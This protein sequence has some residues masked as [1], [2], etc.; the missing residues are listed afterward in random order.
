MTAFRLDY[1]LTA[2]NGEVAVGYSRANSSEERP[3]INGIRNQR[4]TMKRQVLQN[5]N[6]KY[7]GL[8]CKYFD[9]TFLNNIEM[10]S[11]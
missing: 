10:R 3:S 4:M 11:V 9:M 8:Y 5:R 2:K 7:A 6:T 1:Q